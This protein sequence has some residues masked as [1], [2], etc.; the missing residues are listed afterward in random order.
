MKKSESKNRSFGN[1]LTI[2]IL[3]ICFAIF[4]IIF[5]IL[6]VLPRESRRGAA[7]SCSYLMA[8]NIAEKLRDEVQ[9]IERTAYIMSIKTRES[10][11]L[12]DSTL[13]SRILRQCPEIYGCA[14]EFDPSFAPG[15]FFVWQNRGEYH[16][17]HYGAGESVFPEERLVPDARKKQLPHW[18]DHYYS[19]A[20]IKQQVFSYFY[21]LF[22]PTGRFAGH[23]RLD[24]SLDKFTQYIK[25]IQL[26]RTGYGY[27]IDKNGQLVS[28]PHPESLMYS[29]ALRYSSM[30]SEYGQ[31][32]RRALAEEHGNGRFTLNGT[33]FFFYFRSL[34]YAGWT[35]VLVAPFHEMYG[36]ISRYNDLILVV[37]L[38]F[39]ALLFRTIMRVVNRVLKPLQEFSVATRTI[40]TGHFNVTLP[41]IGE[42]DELKELRDSFTL[43]QQRI[44]DSM[45]HSKNTALQREKI[46]S[47]IRVAQTIQER[48]LP[49]D[50][51][52]QEEHFSLYAVLEQSKSVG[53]DMYSYFVRENLLYFVVGDVRGKGMPAALY[54][55][56]IT[57]LFNYVATTKQS[58]AEICGILNEYL[59]TNSGDDMFITLFA[60]ILNLE[61]GVLNYTNAGHP[62]PILKSTTG[63]KTRFVEEIID[64]PL[65]V[66]PYPYKEHNLQ[67]LPGELLLLYTDGITESQNEASEFYGKENLLQLVTQTD[68]SEPEEL[69]DAVLTDLVAYI[70]DMDESD[71]LTL[72]SIKY[73]L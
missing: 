53:G 67:L 15:G 41:G 40:A 61:T 52:L 73:L 54:M 22:D 24:V 21:P 35:L 58:S 6:Y 17:L 32:I 66:M 47:D 48:F 56:S 71:D 63:Q 45:E 18:S 27:L 60:G 13:M 23:L 37:C 64:I 49:A 68:A 2:R 62:Y 30:S 50:S 10:L 1:R 38:A 9:L 72:I 11:L 26:F 7:V 39:L 42:N 33:R 16:Y 43:M 14:V 8:E 46:E 28:H 51:R 20:H 55:S 3:L 44:L 65:G 36:T 34:P 70:G 25:D 19:Y 5:L 57:T 69:V 31:L 59:Q 12:G 29:D 4:G